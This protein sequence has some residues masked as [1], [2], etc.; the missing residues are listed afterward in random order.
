MTSKSLTPSNG[1]AAVAT[2]SPRV[3][4]VLQSHHPG[5]IG[6]ADLDSARATEK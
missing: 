5:T 1:A 4:Q 2:Q 6:R 3:P